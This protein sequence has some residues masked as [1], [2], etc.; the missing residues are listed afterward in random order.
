[1]DPLVMA[2]ASEPMKDRRSTLVQGLIGAFERVS[3]FA[4]NHKGL[5]EDECEAVLFC[6]RELIREIDQ[7]CRDRH[8]KHDRVM[9]HA[10]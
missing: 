6:A 1:M 3:E 2:V 8:H 9:K 7:H 10:A 4:S 5:P